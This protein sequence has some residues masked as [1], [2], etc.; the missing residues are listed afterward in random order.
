MSRLHAY[1]FSR[2]VIEH[3]VNPVGRQIAGVLFRLREMFA[4]LGFIPQLLSQSTRVPLVFLAVFTQGTP[5][6]C[7]TRQQKSVPWTGFVNPY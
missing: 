4:E 2:P 6:L 7:F 5:P 1:V 3:P